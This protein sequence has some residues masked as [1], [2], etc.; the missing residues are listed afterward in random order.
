MDDTK[1][2]HPYIPNSVPST[3]EAILK[4]VGAKD[5]EELFAQMIPDR[6]RLPRPMD[7]P[8][9]YPAEQD[10]KRHV[11]GIFSKNKTCNEYLSF[12]GAGCWQHFIP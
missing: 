10:L 12:L 2:I 1:F 7:L 4:Y 11:E 6:L 3:K 5:A 9:P 8:E